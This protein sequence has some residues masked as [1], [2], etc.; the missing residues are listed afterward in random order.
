MPKVGDIF[1]CPY[2][3]ADMFEFVRRID[4]G[5]KLE[6]SAVRILQKGNPVSGGP[7]TCYDCTVELESGFLNSGSLR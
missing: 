2:C 5:D 6:L 1:V 3:D 4:P 7:I